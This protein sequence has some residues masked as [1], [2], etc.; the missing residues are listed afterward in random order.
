[1]GKLASVVKQ[2]RLL[3]FRSLYCRHVFYVLIC[4]DMFYS[5]LMLTV[6]IFTTAKSS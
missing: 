6:I 4:F 3:V 2:L 5:W 1:M